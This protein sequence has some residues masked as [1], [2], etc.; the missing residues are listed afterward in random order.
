MYHNVLKVI[1]CIMMFYYVLRRLMS[2]ATIGIRHRRIGDH[3][4]ADCLKDRDNAVWRW[5][6]VTTMLYNKF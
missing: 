4:A 2:H 3:A 6:R 5:L 1:H